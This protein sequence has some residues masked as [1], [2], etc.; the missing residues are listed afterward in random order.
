[1]KMFKFVTT[2]FVTILVAIVFLQQS[3]T[4]FQLIDSMNQRK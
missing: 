4:L 2:V 3:A 1:M